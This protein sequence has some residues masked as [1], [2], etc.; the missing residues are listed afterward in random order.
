ME[1]CLPFIDRITKD[2]C[3]CGAICLGILYR[4][5]LWSP[6]IP[7]HPPMHLPKPHCIIMCN[8]KVAC[9]CICTYPSSTSR[10]I[11]VSVCGG[12]LAP[13]TVVCEVGSLTSAGATYSDKYSVAPLSGETLTPA[14]NRIPSQ[15]L[16]C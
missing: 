12:R 9:T 1:F 6:R 13:N 5:I 7:R 11:V 2:V 10:M 3:A 4:D 8:R 16:S 14:T 15:L